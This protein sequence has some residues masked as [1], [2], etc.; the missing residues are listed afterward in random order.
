MAG[1]E[2]VWHRGRVLLGIMSFYDE[3]RVCVSVGNMVGDSY[4]VKKGLRQGCVM[5]P[6]MINMFMDGVV[7]EEYSRVNGMGVKMNEDGGREWVMSQLFFA[8]DTALVVESAEQLQCL[9]RKFGKVCKRRKLRVNVGK[10]KVMS[11][12]ASEDHTFR[13]DHSMYK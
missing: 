7:K 13:I 3:G 6:W 4:V 11:V 12:R 8:D 9:V 5:S 2:N 10:S 1:D